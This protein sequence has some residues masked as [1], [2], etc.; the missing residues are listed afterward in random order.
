MRFLLLGHRNVTSSPEGSVIAR[1]WDAT[2]RTRPLI[3]VP[4][5]PQPAVGQELVVT[6]GMTDGDEAWIHV[7]APGLLTNEANHRMNV[8]IALR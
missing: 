6:S 7:P 4:F 1:T 2:S 5:E 3:R 8:L